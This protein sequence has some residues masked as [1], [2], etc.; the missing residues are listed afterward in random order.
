[1]RV[2]AIVSVL[3][4]GLGRGGVGVGDDSCSSLHTLVLEVFGVEGGK[5]RVLLCYGEVERALI[6]DL[7]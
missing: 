2:Q 6:P 3:R 1:M 4:L 7:S 5:E